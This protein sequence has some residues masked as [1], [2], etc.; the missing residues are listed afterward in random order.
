MIF[1]VVMRLSRLGAADLLELGRKVVIAMTANANFP[2]PNPALADVTAALDT[3]EAANIAAKG[4]GIVPHEAKREAVRTV[5]G[6]MRALADYVNN[7]ANGDRG[8]ILSAGFG[9]NRRAEPVGILPAPKGLL[10]MVSSF[11]GTVELDWDPVAGSN[12]YT[13]YMKDSDP[14]DGQPWLPVHATTRSKA[15]ITDLESG[16]FYW[17]RV[18]AFGTAGISPASDPAR[19]FAA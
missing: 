17:F 6:L 14:D 7:V 12:Q 3:L 11:A 16:K 19:S 18:T 1:K 4:G 5:E 15:A 10:A 9:T 13:V 2:T 8:V